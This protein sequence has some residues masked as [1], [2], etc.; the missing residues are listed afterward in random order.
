MPFFLFTNLMLAGVFLAMMID[1]LAGVP[2]VGADTVWLVASTVLVSIGV[3]GVVSVESGRSM[4]APGI[5]VFRHL[6][7][8]AITVV[9]AAGMV[10]LA[11]Q[12]V[13]V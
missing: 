8:I 12:M 1:R 11:W 10:A 7:E 5:S 13:G 2:A 9:F 6:I 4:R 3:L